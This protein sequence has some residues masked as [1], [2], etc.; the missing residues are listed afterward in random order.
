MSSESVHQ[1]SVVL[2]SHPESMQTA[3]ER[4]S[5]EVDGASTF[6]KLVEISSKYPEMIPEQQDATTHYE[7]WDDIVKEET[8]IAL[9]ASRDTTNRSCK[10]KVIEKAKTLL[11]KGT[12]ASLDSEFLFLGIC[13][14][15]DINIAAG[16]MD[17]FDRDSQQ[18]RY[19]K[20][21]LIFA[22][23]QNQDST[24]E[25]I[26][27]DCA[28][29]QGFLSELMALIAQLK[30]MLSSEN[31]ELLTHSAKILAR[32]IQLEQEVFNALWF[33]REEAD[34]P[35]HID[36]FKIARFIEEELP[37]RL[38]GRDER[39]FKM[40]ETKLVRTIQVQQT[41]DKT[42]VVIIAARRDAAK[43]L[44][45]TLKKICSAALLD[46]S[47][48][49]ASPVPVI[50]GCSKLGAPGDDLEDF[51]RE[52][53][54][55]SKLSELNQ[56]F[57]RPIS[58]CRYEVT[59]KVRNQEGPH[60]RISAIYEYCAGDLF[61][62]AGNKRLQ[63]NDRIMIAK[64]ML[65]GIITMHNS[66]YIHFDI[67]LENVFYQ[68]RS[69]R[70][71]KIK[72]ADFGFTLQFKKN[73]F[74]G[75]L[76]SLQRGGGRDAFY[77]TPDFTAPEL[78]LNSSFHEVALSGQNPQ[79]SYCKLDAFALGKACYE[80]FSNQAF[81]TDSMIREAYRATKSKPIDECQKIYQKA[82]LVGLKAVLTKL[83]ETDDP[84][85]QFLAGLLEPEP[86]RRTTIQQA[87]EKLEQIIANMSQVE[88]RT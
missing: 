49:S 30:G 24:I 46:L 18:K 29:A 69:D 36:V 66:G 70:T 40:G 85:N 28:E 73:K 71:K 87:K 82:Y 23:L 47:D 43:S 19:E 10:L 2:S 64:E 26:L 35:H 16:L 8:G 60:A 78:F 42:Y 32:Y 48:S 20:L 61:D 81:P 17:H 80:L 79:E 59:K 27:V 88:N 13:A 67:K 6:Q 75:G 15:Q 3:L 83:A 38:N 21:A 76:Q 50:R 37:S 33:E 45:G 5:S 56:C 65:D 52:L 84:V 31:A 1:S 86:D 11:A 51:R 14:F 41:E 22:I 57:V 58:W 25:K 34:V 74:V 63:H 9:N 39:V 55:G 77:G 53:R 54:I 62:L 7:Y 72:I 4:F 44:T 12:I 68:N